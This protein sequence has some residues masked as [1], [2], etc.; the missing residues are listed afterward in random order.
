MNSSDNSTVSK[1]HGGLLLHFQ[2][3]NSQLGGRLKKKGKQ[4]GYRTLLDKQPCTSAD[5]MST[6]HLVHTCTHNHLDSTINVTK[7]SKPHKYMTKA[8]AVECVGAKYSLRNKI[9]PWSSW[10]HRGET[11][12]AVMSVT[13]S[14]RADRGPWIE[15]VQQTV[16]RSYLPD[17][18]VW[19]S[20]TL[21]RSLCLF[22]VCCSLTHLFPPCT[23]NICKAPLQKLSEKEWSDTYYTQYP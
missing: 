13:V 11:V 6:R 18:L 23:K 20:V 8:V 16:S 12:P 1:G 21:A 19:L 17:G 10:T 2:Q 5:I 4:S 15:A 14:S 3:I 22:S 7:S 9:H